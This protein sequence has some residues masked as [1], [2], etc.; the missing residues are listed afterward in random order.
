ML[1]FNAVLNCRVVGPVSAFSTITLSSIIWSTQLCKSFSAVLFAILGNT[2]REAGKAEDELC[3]S[4]K[5]SI[6]GSCNAF[7]DV[8]W[9]PLKVISLS[10]LS[11][12]KESTI[13]CHFV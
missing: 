3:N 1:N 7:L 11:C 6:L 2:Q 8:T 13:F 4:V 10:V 9:D 12:C 5:A